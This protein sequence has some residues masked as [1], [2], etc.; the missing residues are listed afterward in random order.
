MK[1]EFWGAAQTV[2]GSKH[3]ID[4]QGKRLLLD[5]GI[6]QGKRKEAFRK[7]RE[8]PFD[9]TSI[10]AVVLSHAHIDH[11][12]N[13]P[14]LVRNGFTGP[15]HATTA[16]RDLA[17]HML[18]DSAK[19]QESDVKYVNK[20]RRAKGQTPFEPLYEQKDALLTIQ[21]MRS[22]DFGVP[23]EP[24]P[25]VRCT[26]HFA[27]HML[28]AAIVCLDFTP[29]TGEPFRLVFSGDLGRS[30]VPILRDPE[31]IE[32]VDYL[33]MEATYGDRVHKV[34]GNA[35][36]ML[37]RAA[38]ETYQAGGKLIIPA[39]SVGRTQEIVYRLNCLHEEGNLPPFQVFVDSPLAVNATT[40]FREHVE[41]L[42]DEFIEQLLK[43]E[44]QDPL[45][46]RNLHY[47]R[48]VED[49]KELNRYKKPCIIIS[50]SGMCEG[51]RILHHLK[52]NIDNPNNTVLFTGY[53]AP[54]TLGRRILDGH[55]EVK[56][57]GEP[58]PV[59]ARILKLEASS[60][61]ADADGLLDWAKAIS[62]S[63]TPKNVALVHC[64]LDPATQFA[65]RLRESGIPNVMIPKPG[66]SMNLG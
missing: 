60:G 66:D 64:E 14:S 47:I 49:S 58:H 27:G 36:A 13:L 33:I 30:E 11:S 50:A 51:G 40:V 63:G 22:Q 29:S 17:V 35:T 34:G 44:D 48:R 28:G 45:G 3:L 57:Y 12:G 53:Q 6:F 46:F 31:V 1:V 25:G 43:E 15:I 62:E 26:Y 39:F 59:K 8:L 24:I 32:N 54:F 41:C 61:H 2:T 38:K 42:N 18:L 10:D 5:C 4:F 65:E 20:K 19:I 37:E 9:A 56:I 7:N 52:N 16:S 55:K 23:F 21:R